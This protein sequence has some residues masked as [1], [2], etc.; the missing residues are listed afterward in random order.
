MKNH[1]RT[2][3]LMIAGWLLAL[4]TLHA[5]FY[6]VGWYKVAGG[7]GTSTGGVYSVSGIPLCGTSRTPAAR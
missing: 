7:G 3:G 4:P 6:S 2:F 5:Q 1:I